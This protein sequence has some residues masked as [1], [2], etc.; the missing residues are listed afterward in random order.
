MGI[1]LHWKML[2]F[3]FYLLTSTPTTSAK[4]LGMFNQNCKI[5]GMYGRKKVFH[6]LFEATF[7]IHSFQTAH[8]SLLNGINQMFLG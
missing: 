6:F 5:F 2:I 3:A 1:A 4:T 8:I 7:E